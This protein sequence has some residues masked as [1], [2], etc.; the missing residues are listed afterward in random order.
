MNSSNFTIYVP[1]AR[2]EDKLVEKMATL[3][4]KRDRSLSYLV[5]EAIDQY[6][7]REGGK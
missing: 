4:K 3:A 1:K 2:V 5:I 7:E 6:L